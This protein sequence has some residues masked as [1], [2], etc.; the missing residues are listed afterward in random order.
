MTKTVDR[1]RK[2]PAAKEPASRRKKLTTGPGK[3]KK[4]ASPKTASKTAPGR[5]SGGRRSS[6]SSAPKAPAAKPAAPPENAQALALARRIAVLTLDK[7]ALEVILLDVRGL[8]GYADYL[9]V[10]SG[11][12]EPQLTAIAEHIEQTLKKETLRPLG[13]EGQ[14]NGHWVLLDYGDVVVHLFEQEARSFYDLEGLW[15]DAPREQVP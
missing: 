12:S 7:K 8:T 11:E 5:R 14:G 6:S 2:K 1:K 3:P 13:S 15:A 9:V 4:K 10:A